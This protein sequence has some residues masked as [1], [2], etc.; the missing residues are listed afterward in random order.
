M[1]RSYLS[2]ARGQQAMDVL[3][4]LFTDAA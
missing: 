4:E 3:R 1:V 2:T